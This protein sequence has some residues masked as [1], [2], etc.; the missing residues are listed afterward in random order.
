MS[1]SIPPNPLDREAE[2]EVKVEGESECKHDALV[3]SSRVIA[4]CKKEEQV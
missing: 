1:R 2:I 3:R 4:L